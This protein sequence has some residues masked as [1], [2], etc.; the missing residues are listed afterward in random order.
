MRILLTGFWILALASAAPPHA[1]A[2]EN[3]DI[4]LGEWNGVSGYLVTAGKVGASF[5]ETNLEMT[6]L[7]DPRRRVLGAS[8]ANG[9]TLVGEYQSTNSVVDFPLKVQISGCN[10]QGLNLR[11]VGRLHYDPATRGLSLKLDRE[12]TLAAGKTVHYYVSA[13]LQR[14]AAQK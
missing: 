9:C 13:R 8:S 1:N 5:R 4:I 3:N 12:D 10:Y 14:R 11:Y 6:L 2:G 7:V